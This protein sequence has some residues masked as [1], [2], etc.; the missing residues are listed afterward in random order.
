MDLIFYPER[1]SRN[2]GIHKVHYFFFTS[3][4]T[5]RQNSLNFATPSKKGDFV[6]YNFYF[7]LVYFY[8]FSMRV[9]A[10]LEQMA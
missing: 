3:P 5:T 6:R 8:K 2:F 9:K 10:F 1:Q 7:T 4:K